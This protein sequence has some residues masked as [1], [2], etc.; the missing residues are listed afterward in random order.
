MQTLE[1]AHDKKA[2]RNLSRH[3]AYQSTVTNGINQIASILERSDRTHTDSVEED[4]ADFS[5]LVAGCIAIAGAESATKAAAASPTVA[6]Y[7][8]PHLQQQQQQQQLPL[9]SAKKKPKAADGTPLPLG[10]TPSSRGG[11][12]KR[13]AVN[14]DSKVTPNSAKKKRASTNSF[15]SSDDSIN[16]ATVDS[17][18]AFDEETLKIDTD[19]ASALL[20]VSADGKQ[21]LKA[22]AEAMEDIQK[23][24]LST[25]GLSVLRNDGTVIVVGWDDME[26]ISTY[27]APVVAGPEL[28]PSETPVKK[29]LMSLF[30]GSSSSSSKNMVGE[31]APAKSTVAN[32]GFDVPI[33]EIAAYGDR[34][35]AIGNDGSVYWYGGDLKPIVL[36]LDFGA[37]ICAIHPGG[38]FFVLE[39]QDGNYYL[40]RKYE[41]GGDGEFLS[42]SL[43][44]SLL[45]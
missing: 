19:E 17:P 38:T 5:A 40:Q 28:P 11:T 18:F 22:P 41:C 30:F 25:W 39:L 10:K 9:S 24:V 42:F 2:T 15:A 6:Q 37:G 26:Q 36:D 35:Y 14:S 33:V 7:I 29:S 32:I 27:A 16:S 45:L 8:A 23:P 43:T 1:N 20:F 21:F 34:T 12:K 13:P 44:L 31:T 3:N 4:T